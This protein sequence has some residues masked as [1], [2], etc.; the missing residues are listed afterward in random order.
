M[1]L[2]KKLGYQNQIRKLIFDQKEIDND[3]EILD[4]VKNFYETLFKKQSS[5]IVIEIEKLWAI[6]TPSLKNDQTIK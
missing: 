2:E 6:T 3:A 1:N 4:K 5:K